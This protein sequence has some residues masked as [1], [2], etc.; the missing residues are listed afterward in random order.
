MLE[1]HI[2]TFHI[3]FY[4]NGISI[5]FT[6]GNFHKMNLD[7]PSS[8]I[9]MIR[10]EHFERFKILFFSKGINDYNSEHLLQ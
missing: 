1:H 2:L 10:S 8:N 4:E 6:L 3:F 7:V 9:S 5:T